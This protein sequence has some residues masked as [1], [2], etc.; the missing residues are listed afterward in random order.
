MEHKKYELEFH[1]PKVIFASLLH[2]FV[3]GAVVNIDCF[4]IYILSVLQFDFIYQ[5]FYIIGPLYSRTRQNNISSDSSLSFI[6]VFFIN[7]D[8]RT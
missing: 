4:S 1:S 8:K 5:P 3:K 2:S 7:V 6:A